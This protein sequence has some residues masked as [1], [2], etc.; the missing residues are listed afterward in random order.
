MFVYGLNKFRFNMLLV[1]DA[2]PK[3][4]ASRRGLPAGQRQR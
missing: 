3:A 4:A 2:Q 1:S